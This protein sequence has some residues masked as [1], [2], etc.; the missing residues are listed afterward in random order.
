MLVAHDGRDGGRDALELARVLASCEEDSSALV[1]TVL[2][3]GPRVTEYALLDPEAATVTATPLD[4]ARHALAEIEVETRAYAGGSP[5]GLLTNLAEGED[6]DL[7]VIGSPHRG[8]IG[9]VVL[10]SV[11]ES[12][13]SGAPVDVAVAPA[14]YARAVHDPL[15]GHRR[16]L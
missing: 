9:R 15:A 12:L 4:E 8:A 6:F 16:R 13:L 10:G 11:G 1:V 14:G 2:V 7:I 3:T 5:A